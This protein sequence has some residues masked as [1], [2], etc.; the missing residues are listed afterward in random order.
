ML[1]EV[2]QRRNFK[3]F[4]LVLWKFIS[5]HDRHD[6]VQLIVNVIW[7]ALGFLVRV[8]GFGGNFGE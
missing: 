2:V 7:Q 4:M 8:Y 3:E 6:F 1:L 5:F